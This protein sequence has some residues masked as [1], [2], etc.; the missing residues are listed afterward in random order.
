MKEPDFRASII[1]TSYNHRDYLREAIESVL[2]QT[3]PPHEIL[4]ADDASTDGSQ[5][6]IRAYEKRYPGIVRGIFQPH[7]V[8]IPRNRNSALHAV[9]GNYVGILD[10]D[11]VFL[12]HKLERQFEA[13][14]R[15]PGARVV[16]SNFGIVDSGRRPMAVK[17][18]GPQPQGDVFLEVA[19]VKVGILRTMIAEYDAVKQAGFMDERFPRYDGLWLTIKL[20]AS[21]KFAYVDD[22]LLEKREHQT[23]DSRSNTNEENLQDLTGI[24]RELAPLLDKRADERQRAEIDA[25][26]NRW[27]SMFQ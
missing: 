1:I 27:F 4:V 13:L 18:R 19:R 8:G 15:V 25:A 24:Y 20:A 17:W 5:D 16:Y 2:A 11:D 22:V 14:Q 6:L 10:G 3:L 26:W 12:S 9:T 23:S 7:N 21:C